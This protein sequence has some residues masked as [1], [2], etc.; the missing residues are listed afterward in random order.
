MSTK[1]QCRLNRALAGAPK[2]QGIGTPPILCLPFDRC[3]NGVC[4][5]LIVC[6][7]TLSCF[8]LR[9][10]SATLA[11]VKEHHPVFVDC[12]A[13]GEGTVR[14]KYYQ[15]GQTQ[16]LVRCSVMLLGRER[17]PPSWGATIKKQLGGAYSKTLLT[18][19]R[20]D[21]SLRGVLALPRRCRAN[22]T[23][24]VPDAA[25]RR[26]S[27]PTSLYSLALWRT[28]IALWRT[29]VALWRTP[30]GFRAVKKRR[31]RLVWK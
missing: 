15:T 17:L 9:N 7:I 21:S 23:R 29:P 31:L 26:L 4:I 22:Q 12:S 5:I 18:E 10:A 8:C 20:P 3:L 14:S 19:Q 16:N 24:C 30:L 28:P 6:G 11:T 25:C 13:K 1:L 2:G 27:S